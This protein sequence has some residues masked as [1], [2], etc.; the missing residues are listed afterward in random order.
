[1][2]SGTIK[3]EITETVDELKEL[4]KAIENQEVKERIQ[5]LYWLKSGQ[6]KT[7]QAIANLIGKHRV[8]VSRWLSSYRSKGIKVLLLKGKSSGRNRKLSSIVEQSLEQELKER[9]G[10]SSYKEIQ[11]WLLAMHDVEMSYSGVHQLVR[12]RLGGKLKVPRPTHT[13]QKPGAVEDFKKN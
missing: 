3:I 10:F 9:E 13:K 2:M 7:T 8:T 6:V 11:T 4:L 1:M 12:Y 5:A